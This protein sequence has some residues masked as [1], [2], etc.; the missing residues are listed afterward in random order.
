[1]PKKMVNGQEVDLTPEEISARAAEEAAWLSQ[2]DDRDD[3]EILLKIDA[4]EAKSLKAIR[5]AILR[6]DTVKL[7]DIDSRILVLKSKLKKAQGL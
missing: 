1:M 2:K 3:A 6:N 5:D 4:L 7:S